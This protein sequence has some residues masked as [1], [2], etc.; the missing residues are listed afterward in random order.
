MAHWSSCSVNNGPALPVGSCDCGN[1]APDAGNVI[2]FRAKR[3]SGFISDGEK[4]NSALTINLAEPFYDQRDTSP[5][6]M[7]PPENLA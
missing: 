7:P 6:E 5:C 4:L 3:L 1:D 2:P